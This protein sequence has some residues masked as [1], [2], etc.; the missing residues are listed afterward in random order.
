MDGKRAAGPSRLGGAG[1][2]QDARLALNGPY[3]ALSGPLIQI[4]LR[5]RGLHYNAMQLP[6]GKAIAKEFGLE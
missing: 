3:R 4:S 6:V 1:V 5:G 2:R